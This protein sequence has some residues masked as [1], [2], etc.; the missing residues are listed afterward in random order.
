MHYEIYAMLSFV[1]FGFYMMTTSNGS[2]F[3]VTAICAGNS[4]VTG[5][6]PAQRPVT[7]GFDVFFYLCLD[8]RL[9]KQSW[10][11][12]FEMPSC[13]LWRHH[14]DYTVIVMDRGEWFLHWHWG[15]GTV[16]FPQRQWNDCPS[17]SEMIAPAPVKWLPQCQW[18]NQSPGI[19]LYIRPA[20]ERRRYIVTPSPFGWAH[21][22]NDPWEHRK[23]LYQNITN[24]NEAYAFLMLY[25][26]QWT[27]SVLVQIMD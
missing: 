17:A 7:R 24:P 13:S 16:W 8:K 22:Q 14:N 11:W 10:G 23:N 5:E 15:S 26:R 3:R 27:R 18:S 4:P 6:F 2:I 20:N 19:I 1:L 9:S 21:T 12:W 25:M